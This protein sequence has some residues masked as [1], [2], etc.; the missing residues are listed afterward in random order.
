MEALQIELLRTAPPWKKMEM[1]ASLNASARLI[2]LAGLRLRYPDEND[3][4]IYRYL[5]EL[6]L[7]VDLA[8]K[9][10]GGKV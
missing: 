6:L 4:E 5:A 10:L 7:G 8:R 3:A 2:A 1:L 9:V